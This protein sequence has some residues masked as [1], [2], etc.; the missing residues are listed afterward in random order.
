[1]NQ[2]PSLNAINNILL[3]IFKTLRL[4]HHFTAYFTYFNNQWYI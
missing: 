3:N 2:R 1:M 4:I